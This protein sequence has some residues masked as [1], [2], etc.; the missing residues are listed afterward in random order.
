MSSHVEQDNVDFRGPDEL[1][2]YDDLAAHNGPN[3][4]SRLMLQ[5]S[6]PSIADTPV[7]IADSGDGEAGLKKGMLPYFWLSFSASCLML[8]SRAAERYADLTPDQL[9]RRRARRW[10]LVSIV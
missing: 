2:S 9:Q 5:R 1:P 8:D 3:S 7:V 6:L 10:E 4:R